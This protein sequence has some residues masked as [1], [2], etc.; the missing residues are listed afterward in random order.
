M[1]TNLEDYLKKIYYDPSHPASYEGL[2]NL[3]NVLK[4]KENLKFHIVNVKI[5]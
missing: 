3:Y 1:M 5:G 2:K 4:K